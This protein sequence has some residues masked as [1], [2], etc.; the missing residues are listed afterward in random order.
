[1]GLIAI[2]L[3]V[4]IAAGCISSQMKATSDRPVDAS[5]EIF[6][7]ASIE[8]HAMDTIC[9]LHF[10]TPPEM[11]ATSASLTA[12]FQSMLEQ[13]CVFRQ[14]KVLPYEV[15]SDS[16]ALWYARYE[17]CTLVMCPVL[18]Y[19]MDGT[20]N[21]PTKLVVRTRIL[22]ARTGGVLWDV[23][24]NG[25]SEPGRDIDLT[26]NTI[27]GEPAQRCHVLADCL[28]RRFAEY[29]VQPQS[30]QAQRSK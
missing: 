28:A 13:R 3:A 30:N 10:S 20:G 21:V 6:A 5:M 14:I 29:L 27:S 9:V 23:K 15:K 7:R 1:M 8:Q 16:E 26:W 24:Q 11:E 12:A 22:D 4:C 19:M 17:G 25:F 18:I 2:L